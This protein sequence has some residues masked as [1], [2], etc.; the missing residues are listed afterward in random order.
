MWMF[1]KKNHDFDNNGNDT[2]AAFQL[3]W[4]TTY[5][6]V[7]GKLFSISEQLERNPPTPSAVERVRTAC[8]K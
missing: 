1:F 3:H 7:F 2:Q 4:V 6:H 8:N 5:M